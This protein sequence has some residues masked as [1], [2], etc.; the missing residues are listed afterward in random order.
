MGLNALLRNAAAPRAPAALTYYEKRRRD[1]DW[2]CSRVELIERYVASGLRKKRKMVSR[3]GLAGGQ[4]IK[5]SMSTDSLD[6][7][8]PSYSQWPF[9][10]C[11]GMNDSRP[12]L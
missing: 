4:G 9:K 12:P 6:S 7:A 2:C 8:T 11:L 1:W 3:N 10:V 5:L